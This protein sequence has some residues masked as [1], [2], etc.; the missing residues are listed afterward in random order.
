M[1][2]ASAEHCLD[3]SKNKQTKSNT[4]THQILIYKQS[5]KHTLYKYILFQSRVASITC[6]KLLFKVDYQVNANQNDKDISSY[7][8]YL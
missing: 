4:K 6:E 3:Y 7:T 2:G 1:S 5:N 8:F